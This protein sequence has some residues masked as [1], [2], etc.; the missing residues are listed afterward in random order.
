MTRSD[1]ELVAAARTGEAGAFAALAERHYGVLL[2]TCRRA[3]GDPQWARD[4]AQEAVVTAMLGL[5]RLR[6]DERFGEWL[7]GIALNT[8]RHVAVRA[9]A[10]R[11]VARRGLRGRR[12]GGAL[13]RPRRGRRGGGDEGAGAAGDR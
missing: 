7:L 8:C 9:P 3:L 11:G 2:A 4:A 13:A 10:P 6:S 5:D 1:A 12:A